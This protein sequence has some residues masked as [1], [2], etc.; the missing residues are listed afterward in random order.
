MAMTR[1]VPSEPRTGGVGRQKL[2]R[3]AAYLRAAWNFA[4]RS[5]GSSGDSAS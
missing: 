1:K 3:R 5:C 4:P 2:G